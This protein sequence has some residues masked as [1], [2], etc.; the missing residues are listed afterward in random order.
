MGTE[1]AASPE[2][3]ARSIAAALAGPLLI[4]GSVLLVLRALAFRGMLTT[5]HPDDLA[6]YMPN[7]CFLGR[8]LTSGHIPAWNPQVMGGLPFAADPLSGWMY[9]PVMG[10]FTLLPCQLAMQWFIVLQSVLAGLGIYGFL[11][12]EGLSRPAATVGGLALGVGLAGSGFQFSLPLASALAWT[13]VLLATMSRF[14][15]ST[16]WPRRLLWLALTALSWG[17]L[18][19]THLSEGLV[20]GTIVVAIYVVVRLVA[21]IRRRTLGVGGALTTV[22][23]LFAA[24]PLLNLAYLVPRLAYLPGSS[25]GLGYRRLAALQAQFQGVPVGPFRV[26]GETTTFPLRFSAPLGF[27]LGVIALGLAFAGWR[28]R[29]HVYLFVAFALAGLV[30]YLLGLH[31]VA[32]H[33]SHLLESSQLASDVYLHMPERFGYPLVISLS[34]C[35][36]LGVEGWRES[37]SLPERAAMLAPGVLVWGLLPIVLGLHRAPG[38]LPLLAAVAGLVGLAL[39]AARPRLLAVVP[40][41]VAAELV[42]S[43]VG[44]ALPGWV[45][46]GQATPTG[47]QLRPF[48]ELG[49]GGLF[50]ASSYVRP[51]PIATA[52]ES[53]PTGRYVSISPG[54]WTPA[55]YHVRRSPPYWGL[56]A[57][58]RSMLFGLEEGQGF[59]SIQVRRYWTFVRAVDPKRTRYNTADFLHAEPIALNLLQVAYLIQSVADAPAVP[60]EMPLA[61]EGRWI[62]YELPQ[63]APRASVLTSWS[64]EPSSDAAL[65]AVLAPTFDPDTDVILEEQPGLTARVGTPPPVGTP[66]PA[67]SASYEQAGEQAARVIVTSPV[68]A[69]VLIRNTFDRNWRATVDGRPTKVLAADYLDQGVPVPAGSH[70]IALSYDDPSVAAGMVGSAIS[71]AGLLA[72]A[73]LLAAGARRRRRATPDPYN[74]AATNA[75]HPQEGTEPR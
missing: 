23:L 31:Y 55:G 22:G 11:R 69:I 13:A 57:M 62:L 18:A 24:L 52:L 41:L 27:Y 26:G 73:T 3:G 47:A 19:A 36:G 4:T 32:L 28:A 33:L 60:N 44:E 65:Q 42:A 17:Q 75:D 48:F 70:T 20:P 71:L 21:D 10:L 8:Q 58:Q 37:R 66:V 40:L 64:L 50:P 39:S 63:P 35:A 29:R 16:S 45:A 14:L 43:G 1:E 51:G 61:Q 5:Q 74:V 68:P 25:L 9:L 7:W 12:S 46:V 54:T 53:L 30:S 15:R 38:W 6:L 2:R 34:V 67:G 49:A 72:M 59:N 56:M